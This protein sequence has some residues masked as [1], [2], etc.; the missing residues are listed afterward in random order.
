M[1]ENDFPVVRDT[2][3]ASVI[4]RSVTWLATAIAGA[5]A[6]SVVT[7][8]LAAVRSMAAVD[9][10]E[11]IRL[12]G[13]ALAVAAAGVWGL[14][15]F[16]P[17]YVATAIPGVAFVAVV[18]LSAMVAMRADAIADQWRSSRVRRLMTWLSA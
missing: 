7:R 13:I 15:Q 5:A 8:R 18:A 12:G 9:T 6:D 4:G 14:S 11:G 17:R 2:V 3:K 1:I 10:A 16:I